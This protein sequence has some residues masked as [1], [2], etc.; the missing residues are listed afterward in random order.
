MLKANELEQLIISDK[1]LDPFHRQLRSLITYS[2][3]MEIAAGAS[4]SFSEFRD[5]QCAF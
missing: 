2:Q 1:V 3:A 4:S 5:D